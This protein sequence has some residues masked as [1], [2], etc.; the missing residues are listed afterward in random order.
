[1]S[2]LRIT[3]LVFIILSL[4]ACQSLKLG[5]VSDLNSGVEAQDGSG[6]GDVAVEKLNIQ[7]AKLLDK[8]AK[9]AGIKFSATDERQGQEALEENFTNQTSKWIDEINKVVLSVTPTRTFK[10]NNQIDCRDYQAKAT[11]GSREL[12]IDAIACRQRAG[13]WLVQ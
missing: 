9:E 5:S 2:M 8:L 7:P 1:M 3:N 4:S 13:V 6:Q 11:I 10:V 12:T